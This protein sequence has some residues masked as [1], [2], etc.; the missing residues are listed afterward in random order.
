MLL[1]VIKISLDVD[2]EQKI[3]SVASALLTEIIAIVVKS[4]IKTF[5]G[6]FWH[7]LSRESLKSR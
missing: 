1:Y 7:C 5:S 6:C 2:V 4:S 3:A